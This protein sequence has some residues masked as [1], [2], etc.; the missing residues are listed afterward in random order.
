M[1]KKVTQAVIILLKV[2]RSFD[3]EEITRKKLRN[4]VHE[5]KIIAKFMYIIV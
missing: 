4:L 3:I 5:T 1:N 2:I